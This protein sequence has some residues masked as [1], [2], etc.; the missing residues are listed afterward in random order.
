ME[1][2]SALLGAPLTRR[3][4]V[5]AGGPGAGKSTLAAGL[6]SF[7]R[8]TDEL[9]SLPWEQQS[10]QV[11]AWILTPLEARHSNAPHVIEGVRVLSGLRKAMA[12]AT[13]AELAHVERVIFVHGTR[14]DLAPQARRLADRIAAEWPAVSYRL[15]V[16][17]IEVEDR[18]QRI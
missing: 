17:G 2:N 7:V 15:R 10:E 11:A 5:I 1:L 6:S 16:S 9:M 14:R 18:Y 4:I 13:P 8:S 12:R 3:V